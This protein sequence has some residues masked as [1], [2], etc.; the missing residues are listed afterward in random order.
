MSNNIMKDLL[1]GG[2]CNP[3]GSQITQGSNPV[4]NFMQEMML[5]KANMRGKMQG[6][7]P[8]DP[9]V[10]FPGQ[11]MSQHMAE[12]DQA[13]NASANNNLT[14]KEMQRMFENE[15]HIEA[16]KMKEMERIQALEMRKM[17]EQAKMAEQ[18]NRQDQ[19]VMEKMMADQWKVAE[20][21]KEAQDWNNDFQAEQLEKE[22]EAEFAK[23]ELLADKNVNEAQVIK[24]SANYMIEVMQND[25][26]PRFKDSKLLDFLQK[27][28]K[29]QYEIKEN[30]LIKN[31]IEGEAELENAWGEAKMESTWNKAN[32]ENVW[33]ESKMENA[34]GQEEEKADA[35]DSEKVFDKIWKKFQAGEIPNPEEEL[36][37]EYKKIFAQ[38]EKMEKGDHEDL[39]AD[40]WNVEQDIEEYHAYGDVP[41]AYTF[42][43]QNQ[44]AN[45]AKA[46]ETASNLLNQGNTKSAILALESHLKQHPNDANSWRVLGKLHMDN[47]Q[48]K[49]A[50]R[51][52]LNSINLDGKNLDTLLAL[53]V[54]CTNILDE[55]QAMNHLKHWML[56]NP[57]YQHIITDPEIIP[58]NL[59]GKSL[60]VQ[61]VK[62]M[63]A[64]LLERFE[65]AKAMNP[66]D[67][68]LSTCLAVLLFVQREYKASVNLWNEALQYDP[69]NYSLWNKLGATL[70]HLGR[71]DEAMEAYHRALE[72]KPNYVRT[73]VNLGIAHAYKGEFEDAARF[74]L[75]ALSMNPEARHVWS[76]LQTTLLSLQR[77]DLLKLIADQDIEGF[78]REFDIILPEELPDP[79]IEY[80]QIN[81]QFLVKEKSE[82]WLREFQ[83]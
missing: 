2:A 27:L 81:E 15:F 43:A 33:E 34:W 58:E 65:A 83:G 5:G 62:N 51:C 11:M 30:Q 19:I 55:V 10:Q 20:L 3:D 59:V 36:E 35:E 9:N 7:H 47:D 48:D 1:G 21:N 23:A 4:R 64:N 56:N 25:P 45:D 67:P 54:S 78:K 50:V 61:D 22:F 76:Y 71:A 12:F 70:A 73:W 77:Y 42:N 63:C 52:F 32:M 24:E 68:E 57:K 49:P 74:Y 69:N 40:M 39:F 14:G 79:E 6:F 66:T 37:E 28:H 46:L 80:K 17:W 38:M 8:D 44:Y 72:F 60:D 18:K 16:M 82:N 41:E 75:S 31:N 29:G 13:W 26:D 53:G